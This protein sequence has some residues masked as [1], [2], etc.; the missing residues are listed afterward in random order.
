MDRLKVQGRQPK[1]V[2]IHSRS[3]LP[4]RADRLGIKERRRI[5]DEIRRPKPKNADDPKKL[6]EEAYRWRSMLTNQEDRTLFAVLDAADVTNPRRVKVLATLPPPISVIVRRAFESIPWGVPTTAP[7]LFRAVIAES[8]GQH[9]LEDLR[10]AVKERMERR[11]KNLARMRA[12]AEEDSIAMAQAHEAEVE[13]ANAALAGRGKA[14][15]SLEGPVAAPGAVATPLEAVA[16]PQ[17]VGPVEMPEEVAP[18]VTHTRGWG[19]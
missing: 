7:V 15:G 13:R 12:Q 4:L 9:A 1:T 14:V 6:S 11:K 10:T 5:A 8:A 17:D 18:V 16:V 3:K 19:R 2:E